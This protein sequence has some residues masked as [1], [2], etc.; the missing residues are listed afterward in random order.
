MSNGAVGFFQAG[1]T[2][3]IELTPSPINIGATVTTTLSIIADPSSLRGAWR[4]DEMTRD[5]PSIMA[6]RIPREVK[7]LTRPWGGMCPKCQHLPLF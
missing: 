4:K 6:E 5:P 1:R 2:K 3:G 7:I